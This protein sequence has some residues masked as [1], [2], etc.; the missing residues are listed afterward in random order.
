MGLGELN[1]QMTTIQEV[2][3]VHP[4][5]RK[6][7]TLT[8]DQNVFAEDAVAET[9]KHDDCEEK[10]SGALPNVGEIEASQ[11]VKVPVAGLDIAAEAEG[12]YTGN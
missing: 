9:W 8:A 2:G 1:D 4:R 6:V 12:C 5:K 3:E 11:A 10:G 7:R